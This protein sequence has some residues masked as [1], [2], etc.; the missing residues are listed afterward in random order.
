MEIINPVR[1]LK[2][3]ILE[4]DR[5]WFSETYNDHCFKKNG[6][7]DVF[8][9]DNHSF[10]LNTGTIRGLHFQKPPHAQAKIV[11]C[12]SGRIFDVAVDVRKDSPTYGNWI[13]LEISASSGLQIYIPIGFAHGFMTLEPNTEVIYKVTDFYSSSHDSGVLWQD[14]SISIRWPLLE[15]MSPS[16]SDKDMNLPFLNQLDSPFTYDGFPLLPLDIERDMSCV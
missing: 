1:I 3:K 16:L 6:F 8:V 5:G 4:D 2:T 15:K 7:K 9:Q 12:V 11:R 10:S 14:K 13:S